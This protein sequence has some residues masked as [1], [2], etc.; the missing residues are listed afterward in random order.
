MDRGITVTQLRALAV[1]SEEPGITV[2]ELAG[3]FQ[4]R[5]PSVTGLIDR[6][7]AQGYVRREADPGDRRLVRHSLTAQGAASLGKATADARRHFLRVYEQMP[8]DDL[9]A[10]VRGLAAFMSTYRAL[11][12]MSG[13]DAATQGK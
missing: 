3:R 12:P 10:V 9:L 8:E 11:P 1:I 13:P 2:G 5:P 7:V 4:V 6:L